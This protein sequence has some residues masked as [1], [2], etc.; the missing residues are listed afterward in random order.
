MEWCLTQLRTSQLHQS[1]GESSQLY[2]LQGDTW[3][4]PCGTVCDIFGN[5]SSRHFLL[6]ELPLARKKWRDAFFLTSDRQK[7][8]EIWHQRHQCGKGRG[9][10][11]MRVPV[12]RARWQLS[13][14]SV[15]VAL[16]AHEAAW[17]VFNVTHE[18]S[19]FLFEPFPRKPQICFWSDMEQKECGRMTSHPDSLIYSFS[20]HW[21]HKA[22]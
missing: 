13:L 12:S 16:A 3:H 22:N 11:W 5:V 19:E 15:S 8:T 7:V 21:G 2:P 18:T 14:C 1:H 17:S 20:L 4:H 6:R 10:P 9:Q